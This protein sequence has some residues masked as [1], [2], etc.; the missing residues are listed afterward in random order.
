MKTRTLLGVLVA[1]TCCARPTGFA[2][3]SAADGKL[4]Y[5][6]WAN[7][8]AAARAAVVRTTIIASDVGWQLGYAAEHDVAV[9]ALAESES[10]DAA[11]WAVESARPRL[12]PWFPKAIT[13]YV[14]RVGTIYRT[15][16]KV[17]DVEAPDIIY[18]CL[19][20]RFD[21]GT[22]DRLLGGGRHKL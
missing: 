22:C 12:G 8:T 16:P 2:L 9:K 14:D 7:A 5:A 21:K 4:D 3:A 20:A 11:L 10:S 13:Y 15:H 6:W 17:R 1:I 18:T 19:S